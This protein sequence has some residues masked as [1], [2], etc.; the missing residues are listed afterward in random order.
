[1]RNLQYEIR[2]CQK[3]IKKA[4]WHQIFCASFYNMNQTLSKKTIKIK[5]NFDFLPF[6]GNH[7]ILKLP[8]QLLRLNAAGRPTIAQN[9]KNPPKITL[10]NSWNW[11]VILKLSTVWQILNTRRILWTELEIMWICWNLLVKTCE[12]TVGWTYFWSNFSQWE[13]LCCTVW[14]GL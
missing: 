1:M 6:C 8:W 3:I 10:E 4:Q 7:I 9:G 12:I 5:L 2:I 14:L 11:L 13:P